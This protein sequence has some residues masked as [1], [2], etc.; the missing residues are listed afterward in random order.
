VRED[1]ILEPSF[2]RRSDIDFM[3][4]VRRLEREISGRGVRSRTQDRVRIDFLTVGFL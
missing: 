1:E 3:M 2:V 4:R